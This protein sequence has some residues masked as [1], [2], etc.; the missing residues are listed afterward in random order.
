[1]FSRTHYLEWARRFYGKVRFDLATSGLPT[2]ALAEIGVP[3]ARSIDDASEWT[4]L[5]H[6]IAQHND[7]PHDEVVTSLGT[8]HALWLTYVALTNPGDDILVEEPAYEPLVRIAEGIGARVIRFRRDPAEGFVLDPERVSRAMT[9]QTRL[10][11]VTNLHNPSGV[12]TS[13]DRLRATALA[14]Q[15]R[16]AFLIVDEVYAEFDEL[17][18]RQGIFRG[19][20][21]KLGPNIV[22]V[23][24]LTKCYGLGP[25]RIGWL[26][27]PQEVVHRA[28][29]AVLATCGFLPLSHAHVAANVFAALPRLAERARAGLAGKRQQVAAWTQSHGLSWSAPTDGLFGFVL[30]PGRGDL[31]AEIEAAASAYDVLVAPG[32]FFGV[33]EGFRIAWSVPLEVLGEGLQRLAR[34]L[35]LD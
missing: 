17:I 12:R 31:T 19:S 23:S 3:N 21:R 5:R 24:S 7:V 18:D 20:A 25:Q 33:P 9:A 1:M 34:A 22:A 32:A 27:G 4:T 26:L 35:K 10:V 30:T 14:A 2:V 6:A 15:S 13:D 29:D 28:Q 16:G 11:V 8:T